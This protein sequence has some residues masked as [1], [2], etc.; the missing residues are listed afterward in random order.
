V[1]ADIETTLENALDVRAQLKVA[2]EN[3]YRNDPAKL[4]EWLT[5]SH[6]LRRRSEPKPEEPQS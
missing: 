4:A 6:I 2:I 1:T 3:H 5:A